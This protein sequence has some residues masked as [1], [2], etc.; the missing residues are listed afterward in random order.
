MAWGFQ[1]C[2]EKTE[3]PTRTR[4]WIMPKVVLR[5]F[6][7]AVEVTIKTLKEA[8]WVSLAVS[9]ISFT[10]STSLTKL[11]AKKRSFGRK[12]RFLKH[13]VMNRPCCFNCFAGNNPATPLLNVFRRRGRGPSDEVSEG[14]EC[15]W[16]DQK[17][18]WSGQG[19]TG[20][21]CVWAWH[22]GYFNHP[23]RCIYEIRRR[24]MIYYLYYN[25]NNVNMVVSP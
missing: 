25:N 21:N 10:I 3:H 5:N 1:E 7:S 9:E 20:R 2:G 23:T 12:I 14:L 13:N 6:G 17:I 19:A 18:C 8:L 15:R 16:Y 11:H 4:F 22:E 24:N